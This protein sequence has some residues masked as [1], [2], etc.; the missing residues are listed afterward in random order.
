V[1]GFLTTSSI[2]QCPH[3]GMVNVISTNT[4]TQAGSTYMLRS[5]DTFTIAGC[6]FSIG[7][8]PHP[9]VQVQWVQPAARSQAIGD[10][11]LTEESVGLCS[12]ADQAVQGTVLINFTQSQDSGL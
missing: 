8:S 12:A 5:S 2:L 1:A 10:F 6:P 3:G 11:T 7:S 4:R 9:C